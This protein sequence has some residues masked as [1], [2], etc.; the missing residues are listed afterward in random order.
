M[1]ND[2]RQDEARI[3]LLIYVNSLK[4]TGGIERVITNLSNRLSEFCNVTILVKDDCKCAYQMDEKIEILTLGKELAWNMHS[5]IHRV[6]SVFKSIIVTIF[7]LKKFFKIHSYDVIYA[8]HVMNGLELYFS[9]RR[10]RKTIIQAEHASYYGYN[11]VYQVMKKWLYKRLNAISVPTKM[12]AGIYQKL[13][14]K[15]FYIPHL[16]TYETT[17]EN[18]L[19]SKRIINVGRLTSDKQQM[20]LIEIW[21]MVNDKIENLDW[22]L[23]IIGDGEMKNDLKRKIEELNLRNVEMIPKTS[24]IGKYYENAELFVFTSKTEGFG[25]VLLETMS[26]GVPC[27]SFDCPSGPRDIIKEGQNG[28]LI[29]CYDMEDFSKRI[30]D[31]IEMDNNH[32]KILS[33]GAIETVKNWDNEEILERWLALFKHIKNLAK[34]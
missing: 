13:G 22:K 25:M 3:N 21:R 10:I 19:N 31:Y 17:H 27:I 1:Q 8:T 24:D 34:A 30:C 29:K 28:Y 32:R 18:D 9:N 26:Y 20:K 2:E 23:Q 12:D 6:V 14:Y 33:R 4:K 11:K 5:R 7:D 15:T 16:N